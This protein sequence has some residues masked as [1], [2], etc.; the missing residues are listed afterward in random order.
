M[1]LPHTLI[2]RKVSKIK[3]EDKPKPNQ[4]KKPVQL[5]IIATH[6]A[7]IATPTPTPTATPTA[8]PP[9]TPPSTPLP[10]VEVAS[11]ISEKDELIQ[12]CHD[13]QQQIEKVRETE[14]VKEDDVIDM[15]ESTLKQLTK[16]ELQ[17]I[18]DDK[19]LEYKSQFSKKLLIT[20]ILGK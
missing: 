11:E 12:E 18:C 7:P 19:S 9:Q 3:K 10:I 15:S 13:L 8:T 4:T 2:K 6:P 5:P 16:A 14:D 1:Q 20:T 17:K